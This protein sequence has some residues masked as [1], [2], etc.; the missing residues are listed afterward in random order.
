MKIRRTQGAF[1]S[2]SAG[3]SEVRRSGGSARRHRRRPPARARASQRARGDKNA[4]SVP[5]T[6]ENTTS[7]SWPTS[8]GCASN[9]PASVGHCRPNSSI[10]AGSRS[11]ASNC[12]RVS[13]LARG[14]VTL[15]ALMFQ[16]SSSTHRL[17]SPLRPT[18]TMPGAVSST[19]SKPSPRR[20][21]STLST[22]SAAA[23]PGPDSATAT[24]TPHCMAYQPDGEPGRGQQ[25]MQSPAG[26][27][28]CQ[29][30]RRW[31]GSCA[32]SDHGGHGKAPRR[33]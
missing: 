29:G 26:Q 28:R 23:V 6:Q 20:A 24:A 32:C 5:S 30:E 27:P 25:V 17:V 10:M 21:A 13:A 8:P 11:A 18:R 15:C 12:S 14:Q 4:G 1:W 31:P 16:C 9:I 7:M 2:R 3:R 33:G 19:Q 22:A